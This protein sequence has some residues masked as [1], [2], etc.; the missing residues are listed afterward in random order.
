MNR[1][2]TKNDAV[3]F[4]GRGRCQP[5]KK[6]GYI[7]GGMTTKEEEEEEG[8]KEVM[9]RSPCVCVRVKERN[10]KRT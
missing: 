2:T 9:Q 3:L 6:R 10:E 5:V 7:V 1:Q 4:I 8:G